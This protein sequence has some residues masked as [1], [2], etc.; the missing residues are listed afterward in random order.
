MSA[1]LFEAIWINLKKLA[2]PKAGGVHK[3]ITT[4]LE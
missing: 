2:H 1:L 4:I 3:E